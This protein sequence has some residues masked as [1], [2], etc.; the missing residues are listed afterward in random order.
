M[1]MA[2]TTKIDCSALTRQGLILPANA[3]QTIAAK[4]DT[5]QDIM[6][7]LNKA[8]SGRRRAKAAMATA[9]VLAICLCSRTES[10]LGAQ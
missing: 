9:R 3:K 5:R 7:L 10:T 2:G 6:G 8:A 4:Y 1:E